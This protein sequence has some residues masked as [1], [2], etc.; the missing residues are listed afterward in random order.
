MKEIN[1]EIPEINLSNEFSA[2]NNADLTVFPGLEAPN[3]GYESDFLNNLL[4][5]PATNNVD[6]IESFQVL[7][8]ISYAFGNIDSN[9]PVYGNI[10]PP[11][12]ETQLAHE[13]DSEILEKQKLLNVNV[14]NSNSTDILQTFNQNLLQTSTIALSLGLLEHATII[15]EIR[16]DLESLLINISKIDRFPI[17]F[18]TLPGNLAELYLA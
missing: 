4:S 12:T 1:Q 11:L 3:T 8:S 7:P 14:V 13:S 10:Q 16:F 15:F 17:F 6:S 5:N 9:K 2:F 18:T